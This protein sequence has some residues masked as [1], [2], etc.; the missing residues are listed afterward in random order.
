M[1]GVEVRGGERKMRGHA[2][3]VSQRQMQEKARGRAEAGTGAE[4]RHHLGKVGSSAVPREPYRKSNNN[5]NN[6]SVE[7][8]AMRRCEVD[9]SRLEEEEG[10][11]S[12]DEEIITTL[13]VP[14]ATEECDHC[15]L[16]KQK[17]IFRQVLKFLG[18]DTCR[19]G[20]VKTPAR[21]A[22]A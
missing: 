20:I 10:S 9:I 19:Q 5:N 15:Y 21:Y 1:G 17:D 7:D 3:K 2:E 22:K 12:A 8:V 16:S 6:H 4:V 18:E 13:V 14:S 11:S